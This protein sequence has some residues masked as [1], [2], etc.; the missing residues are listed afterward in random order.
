MDSG[1]GDE[2]GA[3]AEAGHWVTSSRGQLNALNVIGR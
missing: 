3:E 2:D 1:D